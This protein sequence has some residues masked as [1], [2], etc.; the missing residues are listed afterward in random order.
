M[1]STALDRTMYSSRFGG[2]FAGGVMAHAQ[3]KADTVVL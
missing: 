1:G 3:S 2:R